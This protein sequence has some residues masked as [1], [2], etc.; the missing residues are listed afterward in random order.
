MKFQERK[1]SCGAASIRNALK[2]LGQNIGEHRLRQL[3]G[4]DDDGTSE[5]GVLNALDHLGYY[6]E[7][8]ETVKVSHVKAAV[9]KYLNEGAPLIMACDQDTHWAVIAAKLGERYIIIDSE[10]TKKNKRENGVQVLDIRGLLRRLRK[11]SKE[12]YAIAV[13]KK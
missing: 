1:N 8:Y 2:C 9:K 7:V 12:M 6:G 3:A 10:R 13:K 11:P 5:A 4:T